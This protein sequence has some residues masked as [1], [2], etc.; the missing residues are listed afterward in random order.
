MIIQAFLILFFNFINYYS[1]M[2]ESL[3]DKILKILSP[4]KCCYCGLIDKHYICKSCFNYLQIVEPECFLSRKKSKDWEVKIKNN[5]CL[6]KVYYFYQYDDLI[7][8]LILSIKYGYHF[9]KIKEVARLIINSNEFNT[10]N[11]SCISYITF[12]PISKKRENSRGFNQSKLLAAQLSVYLQIPYL[13][14]LEK[15]KDTQSQKELEREARLSNLKNTFQVKLRLSKTFLNESIL[16]V[17]DICTTGSTLIECADAIKQVFPQVR[18]YGLCLAR[19]E[20]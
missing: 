13:Q 11:F 20:K 7:H 14:I 18:I 15:V 16:L 12:V 3:K 2:K 1:S 6:E 5:S 9:D 19:G 17:D 8:T 4:I 10:I